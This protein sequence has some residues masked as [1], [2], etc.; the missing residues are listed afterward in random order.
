MAA[1]S[2][3]V[4]TKLTDAERQK[5]DAVAAAAGKNVSDFVRDA[6]LS[7]IEDGTGIAG[8]IRMLTDQVRGLDRKFEAAVRLSLESPDGATVADW[9]KTLAKVDAGVKK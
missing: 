9:E 8:A 2:N 3:S 1:R 7:A 6:V 5:L 4:S